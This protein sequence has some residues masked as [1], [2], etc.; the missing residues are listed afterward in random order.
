MSQ[1][2]NLIRN[3]GSDTS[4]LWGK[5]QRKIASS[6]DRAFNLGEL[7]QMMIDLSGTKLKF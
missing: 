5:E 3:E 6:E 1:S 4:F 2:V 7:E